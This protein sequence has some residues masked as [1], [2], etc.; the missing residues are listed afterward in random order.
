MESNLKPKNNFLKHWQKIFFYCKK[1]NPQPI[2]KIPLDPRIRKL[3]YHQ[4][5][6]TVWSYKTEIEKIENETTREFFL[7]AL[8]DTM[9]RVANVEKVGGSLRKK[10]KPDMPVAKL[11]LGKIKKMVLDLKQTIFNL[12]ASETK[13]NSD[14]KND[15]DSDKS[16]KNFDSKTNSKFFEPVV[17]N[18]DA[19]T[20][21]LE[22]ESVGG[23]ITSPPYLNKIEYTSVYKLELGL[24]FGYQETKLRA[25]VGDNPNIEPIREFAE[26][27]LVGQAYF[28]DLKKVLQNIF[29]ALRPKGICV[30]NI[31][32]GCLPHGP[33]QSD[34][35]L[36]KIAIQVGFDLVTN[37]TARKIWCHSPFR[38]QKT[39]QTKDTIVVFKKP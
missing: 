2:E 38:S 14:F 15:S 20:I 8:I 13:K 33:V 17:L 29:P 30:F 9:G 11:F 28:S 10:K 22:P 26:L 7:L 5:L 25:F 23:V 37:I 31:A 32:G 4:A 34:E 39:G 3:F 24:F 36:E 18:D 19:R 16:N 35:Y 27:P 1:K 21:Q 6:E 12:N